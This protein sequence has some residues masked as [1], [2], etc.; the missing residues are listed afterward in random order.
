MA[1]T[2]DLWASGLIADQDIAVQLENLIA[3]HISAQSYPQ[4][5]AQLKSVRL[6]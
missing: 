3:P 2:F 6:F 5:D 1:L 4:F